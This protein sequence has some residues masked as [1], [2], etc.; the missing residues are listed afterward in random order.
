MTNPKVNLFGNL[1]FF[2]EMPEDNTTEE[3]LD[4]MEELAKFEKHTK[5]HGKL[6]I[7]NPDLTTIQLK[8]IFPK[9]HKHWRLV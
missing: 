5:L 8:S 2:I 1:C 6:S 9:L 3:S 4:T 7:S